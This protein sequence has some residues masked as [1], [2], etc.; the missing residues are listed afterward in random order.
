M[1]GCSLGRD[2]HAVVQHVNERF[3]LLHACANLDAAV[4]RC[5][6][7]GVDEEIHENL[8]E[9]SRIPIDEMGGIEQVLRVAVVRCSFKRPRA[10]GR[11]G[12]HVAQVDRL[13]LELDLARADARYIQ[14]VVDQAADDGR[15]AAP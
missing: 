2:A 14:Q 11:A 13:E 12:D 1:C 7:G 15:P 3:G 5:V 4:F 8:L 9:P 10:F 6:L